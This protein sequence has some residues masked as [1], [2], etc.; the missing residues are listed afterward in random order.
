VVKNIYREQ[1]HKRLKKNSESENA[2][3]ASEKNVD[4]IFLYKGIIHLDSVPK[5]QLIVNGMSYIEFIKILIAEVYR[6][7]PE[8]Q[9]TGS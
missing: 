5:K 4:C 3:I 1:W 6:V 2:K 7:R 9:E 8:S